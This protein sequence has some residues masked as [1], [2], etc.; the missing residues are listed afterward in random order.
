MTERMTVLTL[1]ERLQQFPPELEVIVPL[2][3]DYTR[4][5]E[6]STMEAADT[7]WYITRYYPYQHKVKP[8]KLKTFLLIG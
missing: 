7:G 5:V 1:I 3:S 2:H 6:V 4:E 8:E